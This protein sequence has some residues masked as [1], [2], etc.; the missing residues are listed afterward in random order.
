MRDGFIFYQSFWNAIRELPAQTQLLLYNALAGYALSDIEPDFGDDA[1]AK[2][3]FTLMR[4]QIDAN[5]RRCEAGMRGGRPA[6]SA[7][8][9][10]HAYRDETKQK[11]NDNQ[12][13]TKA[14]PKEKEKA[15]EKNTVK[16]TAKEKVN[17][18]ENHP[19]ICASAPRRFT[20]PRWRKS[21]PIAAS[22][23]TASTR[24]ASS[25]STRQRAGALATSRCRTGRRRSGLGRDGSRGAQ[26]SG[27]AT[28]Q[29][30]PRNRGFSSMSIP[31]RSWRI[32]WLIWMG[33]CR[34]GYKHL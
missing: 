25:T 14:E 32:C 11:P 2:G 27:G 4:P 26:G 7:E 23:A 16:E 22:G 19:S 8:Q 5:N 20:N 18:K 34:G 6:K 33:R 12:T 3:F 28:I 29:K 24:S 31:T 21:A 30:N 9:E 13:E 15:K 17:G 1:I 10:P